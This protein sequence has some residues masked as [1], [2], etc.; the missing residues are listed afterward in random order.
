MWFEGLVALVGGTLL[1][2]GFLT[3]VVGLLL[4]LAAPGI[5]LSLLPRCPTS[6]F[7]TSLPTAL[8]ATMLI[9]IVLLGPGAFSVD[10]RVFG[11]R[12]IIIPPPPPG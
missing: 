1:V 10:C 12:E 2:V 7:E 3:P 5:G 6:L 8:T 4:G 9:A 11:R